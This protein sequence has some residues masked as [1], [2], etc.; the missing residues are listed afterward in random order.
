MFTDCPSCRRQ[1][2]LRADQLSAA[3]GLVQCGFCGRQ[4]NALERLHDR[5]LQSPPV[6][7][8]AVA[9]AED[10]SVE[11]PW[12]DVP[13]PGNDEAEEQERFTAPDETESGGTGDVQQPGPDEAKAD[14]IPD[15]SGE[16]AD[17]SEAVPP[18]WLLESEPRRHRFRF[19]WLTGMFVL[20]LVLGAQLAWFHRDRLL[21]EYPRLLPWA[22]QVCERFQCELIRHRDIT[23]IEV[24]NRDVRDH[25]RYRDAL[26]V[27]ATISNQSPDVQPFPVV[28]L[29][30][31]DTA[32]KIIAYRRFD[33]GEY[34]DESI[35]IE[36]GM[37]PGQPVHIVLEVTGPTEGAVSFE[38][39][40]LPKK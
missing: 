24:L 34:L 8:D 40:F 29:N 16:M 9:D 15:A 14:A 20:L 1:F 27:N 6:M 22:R 11:E 17:T 38:F 19:V 30:L 37:R 13:E 4:F 3:G 26:L 35:D 39:H 5:P 7:Q 25:P 23:S 18:E 12:F 28:Q 36:A 10:S 31:Y 33:T 21:Q 2:R 32:G